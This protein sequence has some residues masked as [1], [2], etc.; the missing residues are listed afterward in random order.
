MTLRIDRVF[1]GKL[2]ILRLAGELRSSELSELRP[3]I[4]GAGSNLKL[5]LQELSMVDAGAVQFLAGC[6]TSGIALVHCPAYV[7]GWMNREAERAK[8]SGERKKP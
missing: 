8:E 2:T 7:R 3:F 5:D 4:E 6:E 1:D